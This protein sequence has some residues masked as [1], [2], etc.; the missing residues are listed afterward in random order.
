MQIVFFV[1]SSF[2]NFLNLNPISLWRAIWFGHF[3][4]TKTPDNSP[5]LI[6]KL[7]NDF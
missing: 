7:K 1:I 4:E 3:L 6:N 2:K 5:L